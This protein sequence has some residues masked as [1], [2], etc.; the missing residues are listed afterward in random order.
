MFSSPQPRVALSPASQC[1]CPGFISHHQSGGDS[2]MLC[3]LLSLG[4]GAE[5]TSPRSWCEFEFL[6]PEATPHHPEKVSPD[7]PGAPPLWV[8]PSLACELGAPWGAGRYTQHHTAGHQAY[9]GTQIATVLSFLSSPG[10]RPCLVRGPQNQA[11]GP[12]RTQESGPEER[13]GAQPV[14]PAVGFPLEGG[15]EPSQDG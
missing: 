12:L 10:H 1:P 9:Q 4:G 3:P 14:A 13:P 7:P 5:G 11:C 8:G 2:S 15:A 6:L